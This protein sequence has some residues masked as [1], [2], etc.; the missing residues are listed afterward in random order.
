MITRQRMKK[1][2]EVLECVRRWLI[3]KL[4]RYTECVENPTVIRYV[5]RDVKPVELQANTRVM[6][7]DMVEEERRDSIMRCVKQDLAHVLAT[8]MIEK[9]LVRFECCDNHLNFE[10][11]IRAV[12]YI[13]PAKDATLYL[14]RCV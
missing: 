14:G 4:G 9:D 5:Y 13:I 1:I 12:A 11:V 10:K 8:D 2:R 6:D 7:F 3:K